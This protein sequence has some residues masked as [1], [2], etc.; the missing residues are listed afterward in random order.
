MKRHFLKASTLGALCLGALAGCV[1]MPE[2]PAILGGGSGGSAASLSIGEIAPAPPRQWADSAQDVNSHRADGWG[3]VSMPRMEAYLRAHH[4]RL[5]TMSGHPEWPGSVYVLADPSFKASSS[6]AGNIYVSVGWLRSMASEDEIFALLSHEFGHVYL[7]HHVVH[8]VKD[9]GDTASRLAAVGW[10]LANRNAQATAG[11]NGVYVING[12]RELANGTLITAWQRNIEEEADRFGAVM[13]LRAGYSYSQGF[14]TFLERIETYESAE[15][16]RAQA[17][18]TALLAQQRT[19]LVTETTTRVTREQGG[20]IT[21]IG[22]GFLEMQVNMNTAVLD[23]RNSLSITL[24]ETVQRARETHDAAAEREDVLSKAVEPL[25]QGRPRSPAQVKPWNDAVQQPATAE[26]LAHY[27]LLPNVEAALAEARLKEAQKLAQ[28]AASGASAL[29]AMPLYYLSLANDL[30]K[31]RPDGVEVLRR[32]MKSPERSWNLSVLLARRTAGSNR[33]AATA[34]LEEQFAQLGKVPVIWPDLIA[35]YR[36]HGQVEKAKNMSG[37][38]VLE[39]AAYREQCIANAMTESERKTQ[40]AANE[41]KSKEIVD[42]T[43]KRMGM[44]PR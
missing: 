22:A 41:R 21:P 8:D 20:T 29:D 23:F 6:A 2:R 31:A 26:K 14:K 13:S 18:R 3:L 38:C 43:F 17:Q 10:M 40:E 16:E 44:K 33:A 28:D 19:A 37:T 34:M 39:F 12:L 15:R 42:K 11:A 7:N 25:L 32:H 9:A 30:A 4:Q 36:D 1:T 27:A 35:F 5:K 24:S